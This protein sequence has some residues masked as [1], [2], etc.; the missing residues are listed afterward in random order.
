MNV[1]VDVNALVENISAQRNAALHEAATASA[2][3]A[4]MAKKYDEMEARLK[5][6]EAKEGAKAPPAA[7][8]A[9]RNDAPEEVPYPVSPDELEG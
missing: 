6:Y 9:A 4:T 1:E 5:Q 2:A 7:V 3:L 8:D